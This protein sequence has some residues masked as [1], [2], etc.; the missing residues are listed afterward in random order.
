MGE[1]KTTLYIFWFLEQQEG[2]IRFITGNDFK[3]D[4]L[5]MQGLGKT[6]DEQENVLSESLQLALQRGTILSVKSVYY[7]NEVLYFLNSKR[8]RAAIKFIQDGKYNPSQLSRLVVS[9]DKEPSNIY[10]LYEQ[11]IGALTPMIAEELGEAEKSYSMEWI[12]EAI[13]IAA[14]NNVRKWSYVDAILRSWQEKGRDGSDRGNTARNS[15]SYID[16]KLSDFIEH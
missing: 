4:E 11:N 12:E 14:Q 13:R 9:L 16:G 6:A 2:S 1:F 8:G 5:F 7:E 15:R 3:R 10:R